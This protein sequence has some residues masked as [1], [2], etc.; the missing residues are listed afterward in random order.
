MTP[1]EIKRLYFI[2]RVFLSYGLDELIPKVKLT[3]PL[4]IGRF[5]SFGLKT[6]I[7]AKSLVSVYV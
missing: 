1:G 5:G 4:R 6:S 3:L 2:I 7:K